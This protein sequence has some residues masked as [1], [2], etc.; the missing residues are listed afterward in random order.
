MWSSLKTRPAI[1]VNPYL[2]DLG[3]LKLG[4]ESAAQPMY[5]EAQKMPY[6][7]GASKHLTNARRNLFTDG[8][9]KCVAVARVCRWVYF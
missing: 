3:I 1:L 2:T 7:F 8:A 9:V 4:I 5:N 6:R